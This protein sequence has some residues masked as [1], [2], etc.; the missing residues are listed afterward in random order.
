MFPQN[1]IPPATIAA[2]LN[3]IAQALHRL[4]AVNQLKVSEV[5]AVVQ[6]MPRETEL[7]EASLEEARQEVAALAFALKDEKQALTWVAGELEDC[8]SAYQSSAR[9]RGGGPAGQGS[10]DVRRL[11]VTVL[12]SGA[13]DATG[14]LLAAAK[15]SSV[16][17]W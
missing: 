13:A 9:V 11:A 3:G 1:G 6:A 16:H 15:R 5:L 8:A 14:R 4:L 12:Q 2:T 10:R 7:Q 17:I